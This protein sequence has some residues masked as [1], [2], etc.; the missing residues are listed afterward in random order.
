MFGN[1][2]HICSSHIPYC[3]GH[4]LGEGH[5]DYI[6]AYV[7]KFLWFKEAQDA[8]S[9]LTDMIHTHFKHTL[10]HCFRRPTWDCAT[11]CSRA[12]STS[13]SAIHYPCQLPCR[14]A[15]SSVCL[16][17]SRGG[18]GEWGP[19]KPHGFDQVWE[20]ITQTSKIGPLIPCNAA[21]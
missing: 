15:R 3:A 1:S 4:F 19:K 14:A 2:G 16:F 10:A 21:G 8:S 6:T 18:V 12:S 20:H 5:A 13:L 17:S 11:K 7:Y 9:I